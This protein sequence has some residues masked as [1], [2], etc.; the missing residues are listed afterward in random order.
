MT[1]PVL[2]PADAARVESAVT[3][4]AS[5]QVRAELPAT[6]NLS[7]FGLQPPAYRLKIQ[8][9]AGAEYALEIGRTTPTGGLMYVRY[10]A[11]AGV[12][13]V[14]EYGVRDVLDLYDSLP[15]VATALPPVETTS[16]APGPATAED[17]AGT[18]TPGASITPTP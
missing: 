1:S 17:G 14:S 2:E 11:R 4:L 13:M 5:P 12:L 15:Y 8:T 18:A 7:P 16:V 10:P 6:E 3:W 9:G